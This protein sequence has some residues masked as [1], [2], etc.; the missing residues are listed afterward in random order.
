VNFWDTP[1]N[2]L[3]DE[4]KVYDEAIAVENV[5]Q[6]YAERSTSSP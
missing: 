2:G 4:L 5:Q 3:V 6:L 1:Y